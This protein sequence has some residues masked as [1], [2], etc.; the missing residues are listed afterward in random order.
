MKRLITILLTVVCALENNLLISAQ[1]VDNNPAI[2][3]QLHSLFLSLNTE[4]IPTG[5]LRDAAVE[6][7]DF[8]DFDGVL[9]DSN[10]LNIKTYE[11]MLR[12]VNSSQFSNNISGH[13]ITD[14]DDVIQ[15]M[16][17]KSVGD[18]IVVSSYFKKYNYIVPNAL[19]DSLLVYH[20]GLLQDVFKNGV[21][22]NPYAEKYLCGFAPYKLFLEPG[23]YV[24]SFDADMDFTNLNVINRSFD[25]GIGN[26]YSQINLGSNLSAIYSPGEYTLKYKLELSDGTELETHSRIIVTDYPDVGL[27][28]NTQIDDFVFDSGEAYMGAKTRAHVFIRYA[29]NDKLLRKPLFIVEGFD[30]N[31]GVGEHNF[32]FQTAEGFFNDNQL[33]LSDTYGYDLIYVDWYDCTEYIQANANQLIALIEYINSLKQQNG[34]VEQNAVLGISMGGLIARYALC[35][36]E[37]DGKNHQTWTYISHDTP[38]MGANVPVGFLQMAYAVLSLA[39]GSS[40]MEFITST[41]LSSE[42]EIL[43]KYLFGKSVRQMLINSINEF[44]VIDNSQHE[45]FMRELRGLGFPKGCNGYRCYNR[46]V[47]NGGDINIQ[48]SPYLYASGQF[49]TPGILSALFGGFDATLYLW[50]TDNINMFFAHL[51][52]GS[53]D[54]VGDMSVFP[55][56]SP[57]CKTFEASIDY[58]KSFLWSSNMQVKVNLFSAESYAPNSIPIDIYKGSYYSL[59]QSG[60]SNNGFFSYSFGM[61]PH[62]MFI[63]TASSICYLGGYANLT[64]QILSYDYLRDPDVLKDLPFD[65][66]Y[67]D[68]SY[69]ATYHTTEL[70]Y[71]YEWMFKRPT[72][73]KIVGPQIPTNGHVYFIDP[74]PQNAM[75]DWSTSDPS[76]ATIENGRIVFNGNGYVTINAI[77]VDNGNICYDEMRVLIGMP[78]FTLSTITSYID[79]KVIVRATPVP[80]SLSQISFPNN[81]IYEWYSPVA[82]GHNSWISSISIAM[83]QGK[84][85]YVYFR[86]RS[87]NLISPI[88]S[89]FVLGQ[90]YV[91]PGLPGF[92]VM[93]VNSEGKV[94]EAGEN[95]EFVHVK[96]SDTKSYTFRYDDFSIVF[97]YFPSASQLVN[98]LIRCDKFVSDLKR[99]KPWGNDDFII[100]ELGCED[101]D[102]NSSVVL[103]KFSFNEDL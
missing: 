6:L 19:E 10:I 28:S 88:Y 93:S 12:S 29:S 48:N 31:E 55:F 73:F 70:N 78:Q 81:F 98:E 46:C 42:Y 16:R 23:E 84:S 58:Y 92:N 59:P 41:F 64:D 96:S 61:Q 63:P 62:F 68:G 102:N 1:Q 37:K 7:V 2:S 54:V 8:D 87:G 75:V 69:S 83:P 97:H 14:V 53:V 65:G 86:A 82:L 27:S 79:N 101:N 103:L 20:N 39:S 67:F 32:G 18:T 21:W 36:M 91:I 34:S 80:D 44:G 38:H 35:K 50:I 30:F 17:S 57:S 4:R 100:I 77:V 90:P 52:P 74:V 56:T 3:T 60:I 13:N 71:M 76:I 33:L 45:N 95:K 66:L 94:F 49:W 43:R 24:F 72:D 9:R 15:Q 22:Q 47:T 85:G 26:G 51:L 99:I 25:V 11:M 89:I 40:G 5:I